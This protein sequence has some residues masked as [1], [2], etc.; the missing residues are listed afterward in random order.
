MSTDI[1]QGISYLSPDKGETLWV[2]GDQVTFKT[3]GEREG[4]TIFVAKIP[5]GG[6][7]PPHVHYLQDEAYYV[8]DGRFSFLNGEEWIEA[9]AGSFVW[10][11]RGVRHSFRNTGSEMGKLYVTNTLPGSHERWF[12]HVGLPMP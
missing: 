6:G 1:K 7:P 11:P 8:L 2:M 12:R 4:L 10:I 5:P 9:Q 3:V